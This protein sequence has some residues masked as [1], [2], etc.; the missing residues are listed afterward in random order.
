L[1]VGAGT[2]RVS[3]AFAALGC[4]VVAIDPAVAML[5]VTRSKSGIPM[6]AA[7]GAHLPFRP[8]SFDAV[9]FARTLYLMADWRAAL[10]EAFHTIRDGGLLFHEWANGTAGEAW[11]QIR[12]EARALFEG[13][14]VENPF[15]PGAR[16]ESEVDGYLLAHGFVRSRT[17]EAGAGPSMTIGDFLLKLESGELSY[18]WSVPQPVRDDCLPRLRTWCEQT[19]DLDQLTP[20]PR[21]LQWAIYQKVPL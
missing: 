12:E 2:G 17:L 14:G 7:E 5:S 19:F 15:H 11:V 6:V 13:A 10:R 1:E 20:M 18:I 3:I 9:I 21:A 8:E 4:H 16:T